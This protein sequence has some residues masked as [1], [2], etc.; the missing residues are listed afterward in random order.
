MKVLIGNM[1]KTDNGDY[2][3]ATREEAEALFMTLRDPA[4]A[5]D[6][7]KKSPARSPEPAAKK[8]N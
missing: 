7:N 2:P 4:E 3:C 1:V 6:G 8:K 5:A